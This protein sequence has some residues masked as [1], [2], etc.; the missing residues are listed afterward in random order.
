M[1]RNQFYSKVISYL[2]E[3][4]DLPSGWDWNDSVN[5]FDVG[6]LESFDLPDLVQQIE[7]ITGTVVPLS[8]LKIEHFYTLK[9][10]YDT[11][12]GKIELSC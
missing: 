5:L 3:R 7:G 1:E 2:E 6:I 11:I 4:S 8:G 12:V 10:M 9:T